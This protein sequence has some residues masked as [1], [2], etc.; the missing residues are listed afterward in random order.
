MKMGIKP[1]FKI[2]YSKINKS[3]VAKPVKEEKNY[4]YDKYIFRKII[5][6]VSVGK[7][8]SRKNGTKSKLSL[9]IAPSE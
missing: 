5:R 4:E 7:K 3:F 2:P 8:S 1:M 6:R 9:R